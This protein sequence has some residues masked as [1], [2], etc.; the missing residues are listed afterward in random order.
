[1]YKPSEKGNAIDRSAKIDDLKV[2]FVLLG[3]L[4]Y[5]LLRCEK[6]LS[7]YKRRHTYV[8]MGD[9]CYIEVLDFRVSY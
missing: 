9:G 3:S 2:A 7:L 1:M 4:P 6:P 5:C 8:N